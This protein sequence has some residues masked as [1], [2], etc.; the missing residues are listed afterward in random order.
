MSADR[1]PC[2]HCG[3]M[4]TDLWDYSWTTE[5][6]ITECGE[7]G[8]AVDIIRR[9]DVSYEMRKGDLGDNDPCPDSGRSE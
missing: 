2:P 4:F 3:T 6:T 7:C 9:V 1:L 8:G 5:V